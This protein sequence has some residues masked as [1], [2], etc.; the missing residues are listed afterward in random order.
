LP[1]QTADGGGRGFVVR[2]ARD[3]IEQA[4]GWVATQ[5]LSG[6]RALT[7]E[8]FNAALPLAAGFGVEVGLTIDVLRQGFAVVE[9]PAAFHHRVTGSDWRAQRHRA[10]Q[11]WAVWRALRARRVGPT[12]P[13]PR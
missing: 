4:T 11:F 5:P 7:R 13:I 1:I 6:Q 10:R 3:G 12:I 2:L 8:A 9:V